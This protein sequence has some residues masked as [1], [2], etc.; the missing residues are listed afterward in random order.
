MLALPTLVAVLA[1]PVGSPGEQGGAEALAERLLRVPEAE[2]Q[3]LLTTPEFGSVEVARALL[4]VGEKSRLDADFPRA[5]RAFQA[6]EAVARRAGADREVGRGLGGAAEALYMQGELARAM[7][8]A[9]EGLRV[10]ERLDDGAE[11]ADAWNTIGKIHGALAEYP[12]AFAAYRKA[13]DLWTS[14]GDRRNVARALNNIGSMYLNAHADFDAALSHYEQALRIFEEVGDRRLAVLV[15][16]NIGFVH[17]NRGE[18][19]SALDYC[20]R[21]LSMADALGDLIQKAGSLNCL[22]SMHHTRGSYAHALDLFHQSLKLSQELGYKWQAIE[23]WL[24]IGLVHFAQGDYRLAIDA[25]KR[26]LRLQKEMGGTTDVAEALQSIAAAAW[27][28]GER[29]RAEANYRESLRVSEREGH[30]K[31]S[32]ATLHDLGRMALETGRHAEADRL[33]TRALELR[34]ALKDQHGTAQALNGLASLRLA[35]GRPGEALD[36][37]RRSAEIARTFDQ[38]EAR[39]EAQ[40]LTGI[41]LRRLGQADAARSS[42]RQAVEVIEGLRLQVVGRAQGRE[43]FFEGKL[44]P[45]H[46]LMAL[47]MADG[48]ATQALELAERSKARALADLVQSG[49]VNVTGAMSDADRRE[50]GR[51]RAAMVSVNQKV[52][53]ERLGGAPDAGRLASLEAERQAKRS[54]YESFQAAVYAKDPDLQ[55]KRGGAAPFA[56]AEADRLVPDASVAVLEYVVTEETGYLFVLVRDEG[57]P[58]LHSYTLAIGRTSLAPLA[59]RLRERL[60][61]RDLAYA[62]DARRLHDLLLAPASQALTGKTHFVVIPDGPLWDVPFQ[63]LQDASG[64]YV[65]ESAAVSYAPSLTVLRETLR[66]PANGR[67]RT[68]LAMGKADFGAKGTGRGLP[69]MSDLRPLPDAE[70]QVRMIG[71]LYGPDRSSTYL[72]EEAREDRFK[73]E[74]PRHA[75]LHLA[76][77]GVL[78]ESSPLYSHVVLSA[79]APGSS[80]DGL[81]EAWEVLDL[82]LDAD[83]VVLSA[84]ETGRGRI[85]PGEGIVGTMWAFFVAGSRALLVSQWKVESASTTDLMTGFHRGLVQNSPGGKAE[86]LRQASLSL[87]R[88]PRYAHP[89]YWAGFVLV[90]N[91]Y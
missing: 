42:F 10:R 49:G 69:L 84:C 11:E 17:G 19:A 59:R 31:M 50:E 85:A 27:R 88:T 18:Y 7:A 2:R 78:E 20:A 22:A 14:A 23:T 5:L 26:A 3:Q 65:I 8:A 68:L 76:T 58:K 82:R 56:F 62:A 21:A 77:H 4:A 44:S 45:Y 25:Y 41:A 34:E 47:A 64:R 57:P 91:P 70:R 71:A 12:D 80:E 90:G 74:A 53:K 81:L 32:A 1:W 87:L 46:E 55:V 29:Q 38:P 89:F 73:A 35:V 54:A 36:L 40:T 79:G 15:T 48:S 52:H 67:P 16:N 86:H 43:R 61:A 72:G 6:A 24:N 83:L 13:L 75:V 51:L 33:L 66:R 39:W 9:R 37:A 63:A 60:A 28:L 30:K